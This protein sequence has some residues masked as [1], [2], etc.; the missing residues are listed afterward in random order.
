MDKITREQIQLLIALQDKEAA[1]LK[2]EVVLDG[3]PAKIAALEVG[4]KEFEDAIAREKETLA[5]LKKAY[6]SWDAEIQINQARV[7]K[8]EEQLRAVKTNKEYQVILKEVE[9]IKKISSRIEDETIVC[10]EKID[11]AENAVT[12]KQA[13]YL[14][15]E[16][17]VKQQKAIF[18]TEADQQRQAL[19]ELLVQRDSLCEKI[20]DKIMR[21]YQNIKANAR[22][23]AVVQVKN[24]IC[25]GCHMNIPPQMYNELHRENELRTCPHCHR[26]LYVVQ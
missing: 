23:I 1:A 8:R 6:R 14:A 20:D 4:L 5:E 12:E 22:G 21:L 7:K 3:L 11:A 16:T 18:M 19:N 26:M 2:I 9:E 10:L 13:A 15:E 25:M 24:C 17:E